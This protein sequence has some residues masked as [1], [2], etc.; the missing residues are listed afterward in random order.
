MRPL[1]A[2]YTFSGGHGVKLA[3]APSCTPAESSLQEDRVML[4]FVAGFSSI[5]GLT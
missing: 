2:R 4:V 1:Q 5:I 3:M